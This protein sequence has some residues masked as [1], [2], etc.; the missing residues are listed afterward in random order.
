VDAA[1]FVLKVNLSNATYFTAGTGTFD[2]GGTE[3]VQIKASGSG[4]S[5]S[6]G[7]IHS[8]A[9]GTS[10]AAQVVAAP[11][12]KLIC[13]DSGNNPFAKNSTKALADFNGT[14]AAQSST[15]LTL[16]IAN[17]ADNS[18]YIS[19]LRGSKDISI[20]IDSAVAVINENAGLQAGKI[21]VALSQVTNSDLSITLTATPAGVATVPTSVTILSGTS[22]ATADFSPIDDNVVA[23]NRT[24]TITG[25]ATGW[26]SGNNTATV[27][28]VQF[29]NPSVVINEVV[30]GGTGGADVV[31]LLVVENSLNMVGMILKDFATN[32]TGDAGGQFTFADNALW[33]SVKAGTL[34]V[35][36]SDAAATED[37]DATD[38]VV[39]VKLT[40]ATYFAATGGTFD[41]SNIDMV[42]IKAAGSGGNGIAGAI[43][44]FGNGTAGS[45]FNLANGA[46]LLFAAGGAGG[47]AD[48]ATSAIGDYNGTG[49][50]VGNTLGL[51]NNANNQTYISALRASVNSAPT[52][53]GLTAASIAE[54]NAVDANVGTLSTTDA[55]SSDTHTYSLVAGTGDT[56]NGSFNI[57]GTWLRA[58]VAFDF[59]TKSSYSIRVRT[60]DSAN[61]TF[62]KVFTITV[63]DVAEGSAPVLTSAT[64][65][66]GVVGAAFSYQ[67]TADNSPTTFGAT[68]L[69]GNISV[70]TA[71]GLVSGTPQS[72]LF[73]GS[74]SISAGNSIGTNTATVNVTLVHFLESALG[75]FSGSQ[76]SPTA[77]SLGTSSKSLLGSV[78]GGSDSADYLTFTVPSGY[79]L[80]AVWLRSYQSTDNVAFM[81][82]DE[83]ATWSAAQDTSAMLG[84]SHFGGSGDVGTDLLAKMNVVGGVLPAGTYTIWVQQ[85]GAATTYGLEF[86]LS[87]LPSGSTFAG[88]S[89]GAELNSANVGKYAIGGASSAIANDGEK[90]VVSVA[91]GQLV[92]SAIVRTNGPAGMAVI[93]E[94][95]SSLA[96]YGTP[97]SITAVNGQPAAVQ[98]TVPEGCQR[99]EFKVNQY[100]GR[101]FLRLKAT[102]P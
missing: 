36:T 77:I 17:N 46:K 84:Y 68:G 88:W 70:D 25:S 10:S 2:V 19:S 13:A 60:T 9:I 3:M 18:T 8:F 54:N 11:A 59:E 85:L 15:S 86:E 52:D 41:V 57:S 53:I 98:G 6:T 79:R 99:Q 14:D 67:I 48:N 55:D 33:Q 58:G 69:P 64:S 43:H 95:V 78:T 39:T 92:L 4:Q 97:A 31:E 24:V 45:L 32:M 20:S 16:G 5:G 93:G 90:P 83:G 65:V 101:K 89:G 50:T 71:T 37:T 91:G 35:L 38:G 100:G 44:T 63:T 47:G 49:V 56:D 26:N 22:S 23:G 30:N 82:I 42:M 34:L 80:D 72:S 40:N 29:N 66:T 96:D 28:D 27:V 1:D 74:F 51:A 73:G 7:A 76:G 75:D 87:A 62:D 102:L 61:N 12:P 21:T 94:A 81:A